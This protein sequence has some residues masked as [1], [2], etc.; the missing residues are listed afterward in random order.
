[1]S[2]RLLMP[3][4]PAWGAIAA[5]IVLGG[6]CLLL[7]SHGW[8]AE[9]ATPAALAAEYPVEPPAAGAARA[10]AVEAGLAAADRVAAPTPGPWQSLWDAAWPWA[11]A[12][13][14]VLLGAARNGKIAPAGPWGQLLS[15]VANALWWLCAPKLERERDQKLEQHSA[16]VATIARE[17]ERLGDD[18][19]IA[20]LKAKLLGKLPSGA[21]DALIEV[22]AEAQRQLTERGLAVAQTPPVAPPAR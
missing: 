10:P 22:I 9:P 19:T 17:I 13:L 8:G 11:S 2:Q 15:L 6:L 20:D 1:M 5:A 18:A 14:L 4:F 16:A 21:K 3:P 12:I 7:G